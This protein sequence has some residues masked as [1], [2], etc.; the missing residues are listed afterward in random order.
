MIKSTT[1]DTFLSEAQ[2]Q[3]VI[4]DVRT[5]AEFEKG[6]IIGA[7]NIPL[8]TNEERVVVG[9]LYIQVGRD[10]A[11]EKGLEF[12]GPRMAQIVRQAKEISRGRP[13]Y[14]YCWRGGMRSGSV[15]WL[16]STAGLDVTVLKGGYKAYRRNFEQMLQTIPWQIV[17]LSGSTGSGKTELLHR[18]AKL[19]EQ[20]LD[21]E[22]LA[23]H[24]GSVFGA[25]GQQPQPTTEHFM[26]RLNDAFRRFDPQ[27]RIWCEGESPT[28]GHVFLP[29]KLYEIMHRGTLIE[30]EMAVDQRMDRLMIEYGE[31]TSDEFIEAFRKIEKR[32]GREQ[33]KQAIEHINQGQIR[34]AAQMA[35]GYYDKCYRKT[36]HPEIT[37]TVD[38]NDMGKSSQELKSL[39]IK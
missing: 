9:T 34:A 20:V 5:P 35:L 18:L 17:L 1:V 11:I 19:G 29:T 15:G 10:E 7:H 26:N 14:I 23:N 3:G 33:T 6:H 12:V 22:G 37:I 39:E 30:V 28:I 32:F 16:L 27:R 38:N 25:M 8:F 4:V 21:L 13:L 24:K 36:E 2:S 31:F